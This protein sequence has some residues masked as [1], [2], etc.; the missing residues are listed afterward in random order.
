M[1]D[2]VLLDGIPLQKGISENLPA[3]SLSFFRKADNP[4]G[5]RSCAKQKAVLLYC[6]SYEIDDGALVDMARLG[7]R[8]LFAFSD[9]LK[10]SGFRRAILLS[11]MRLLVDAARRAGCHFA[12]CSMANGG[13]EARNAREL[14]AFAAFIGFTQDERAGMK[15]YLERLVPKE[16]AKEGKA[17]GEKRQ[18]AHP[19]GAAPKNPEGGSQK[20]K[21]LQ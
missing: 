1:K 20:A 9:V 5:A 10:E 7:G 18:P 12:A 6:P 4:R 17:A 19:A 21:V 14:L 15:G 2:I 11:K 8:V 16:P 13:T 3:P